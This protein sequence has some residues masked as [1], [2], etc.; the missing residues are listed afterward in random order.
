M[1]AH[2]T[3]NFA[4][5]S[6]LVTGGTSGIG[7]AIAVAFQAAGAQVTVTGLSTPEID[8]SLGESLISARGPEIQTAQLDVQDPDAIARLAERL[9]AARRGAD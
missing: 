8:A 3:F 1:T 9:L 7:Q 6:V 2:V 4:G 5:T